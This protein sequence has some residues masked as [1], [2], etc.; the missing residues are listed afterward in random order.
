MAVLKNKTQK[1]FTMISNTILRDKE[2]SMKDRGV[3]CT[4]CSLPDGWKFSIEGLSAIVTDGVDAI[5]AS[6]IKLEKMGYMTR[7][8]TRGKDGKYTSEI[9]V[10]TKRKTIGDLP[11]RENRH[12][13]SGTANPS[14]ENHGGLSVTENP[15][16]YNTDNNKKEINNDNIKSINQY[17]KCK[18]IEGVMEINKYKQIIADNIKYENLLEIAERHGS[19]EVKMVE[20]IYSV[21]CDMVCVKRDVVK[22]KGTS[23]PWNIV[24]SRFLK[25]RFE[26]IASIL[27]RVID[28]DLGI[29]NMSNYLIST[30][31]TQSLVGTIEAQ[32]N[33]HDDYLKFLRDKPYNV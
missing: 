17:S 19:E 22:I 32:A 28:K 25:L 9:E 15:A 16:Q 20:E 23:Y 31:Y 7:S 8:K 3:L 13:K 24:K 11:S 6:V 10:Y 18:E 27:N 33:I 4:I 26:H 14:R 21:I 30:L 12:G 5:R 29:K 1:N 2:L